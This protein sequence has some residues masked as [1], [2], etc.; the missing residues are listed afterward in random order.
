MNRN[1]ILEVQQKFINLLLHDIKHVDNWMSSAYEAEIFQEEHII[2]LSKIRDAYDNNVL[3]TRYSFREFLKEIDTKKDRLKLGHEFSS[4]L[5]AVSSPDDFHVY[6]ESIKK[7]YLQGRS[8]EVIAEFVKVKKEK[9]VEIAIKLAIDDLKGLLNRDS[10]SVGD[11]VYRDARAISKEGTDYI[12]GVRDGTIEEIPRVLCGIHEIDYTMGTGF[13][14]G[15]LTLICA[16][17]AGFKSVMMQNIAEGVRK[18]GENGRSVLYVPIEMPIDQMDRRMKAMKAKVDLSKIQNPKKLSDNEVKRLI[19]SDADA[20]GGIM[21]MLKTPNGCTVTSIQ[22]QIENHI[23]E[24]KPELV[25]VDYL[26]NLEA[27]D[28][29]KNTNRP[30]LELRDMCQDL[31]AGGESG[32]Y[33]VVSGAQLTKDAIK[34]IRKAGSNETEGQINAEDLG[35]SQQ[36]ANCSDFVLG[37]CRN[38]QQ[39][40]ELLDIYVVKSRNG[41][42]TFENNAMK[43]TL[44][45]IGRFM[46]ISSQQ[47]GDIPKETM[48]DEMFRETDGEEI[49]EKESG[50]QDFYPEETNDAFGDF[51]L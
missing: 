44:N 50:F 40:H 13:A 10:S 8:Q 26:E 46:T 14:P 41:S 32:G 47:N 42:K 34:R 23:T 3:L 29:K 22:K 43:A 31:R 33:A 18:D 7:Y 11:L 30:D 1:E 21:Y 27:D 19:D 49:I 24:F 35:G 25:V 15:T 28:G 48:I 2:I 36:L 17:T 20:S 9:G 37:Q 5:Q 51:N 6:L 16:E 12:V 4:C 45:V 38:P 39:P